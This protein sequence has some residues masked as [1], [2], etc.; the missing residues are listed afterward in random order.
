M[1]T[2]LEV[3][4]VVD[5]NRIKNHKG[6]NHGHGPWWKNLL[7]KIAELLWCLCFWVIG[8]VFEVV[9]FFRVVLFLRWCY[10]WSGVSFYVLLFS[11]WCCF[12]SGVLFEVMLFLRWW[13]FLRWCYFWGESIGGRR[14]HPHAIPEKIKGDVMF[15]SRLCR[16][17]Y[18]SP[19]QRC[20]VWRIGFPG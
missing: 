19:C 8:V 20:R 18:S 13:L 1:G 7:R 16:T 17:K 3:F 6:K 10:V 12:W 14:S 15:I 9:L 4:L 5:R 11:R 2:F